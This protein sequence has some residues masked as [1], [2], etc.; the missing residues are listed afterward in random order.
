MT[1]PT[2]TT[3]PGNQ[4]AHDLLDAIAEYGTAVPA[5]H[6]RLILDRYIERHRDARG[7]CPDTCTS[8]G[9]DHR[10]ARAER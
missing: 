8:T 2:Q 7:Y 4:L 10:P 1:T 3:D 5:A 9:H 6:L